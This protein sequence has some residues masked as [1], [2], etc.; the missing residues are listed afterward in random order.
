MRA[1]DASASGFLVTEMSLKLHGR[2]SAV[3]SK[4]E[5][6]TPENTPNT[7]MVMAPRKRQ[8]KPWGNHRQPEFRTGGRAHPHSKPPNLKITHMQYPLE[9]FVFFF[10]E[11]VRG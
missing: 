5:R 2:K 8:C 10:S 1:V 4:V 3:D 11:R 9:G 7:S 6:V